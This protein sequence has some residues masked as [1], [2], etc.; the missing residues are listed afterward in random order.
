MENKRQ[1]GRRP[2]TPGPQEEGW[3]GSGFKKDRG[4]GMQKGAP[5]NAERKDLDLG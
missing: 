3:A 4:H 2:R 5:E 1:I